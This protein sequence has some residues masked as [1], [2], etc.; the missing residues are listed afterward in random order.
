MSG[1]FRAARVHR[2]DPWPLV[3]KSAYFD[4][5]AV[6]GRHAADGSAGN[7]CAGVAG[8]RLD[9][10]AGGRPPRAANSGYSR[11]V[12]GAV[13]P[14]WIPGYVTVRLIAGGAGNAA[15]PTGRGSGPTHPHEDVGTPLITAWLQTW[16]AWAARA[17]NSSSQSVRLRAEPGGHGLGDSLDQRVSELADVYAFLFDGLGFDFRPAAD[18]H[19]ITG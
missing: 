7:G 3:A 15:I 2:R 4:P 11:A 13:A 9:G 5:T 18:R 16:E 17:S 10:V 6:T 14:R 8:A 19:R 1:W 12:L